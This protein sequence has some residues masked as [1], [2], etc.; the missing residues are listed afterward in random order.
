ME[1]AGFSVASTRA[2]LPYNT[3][4]IAT[5][6]QTKCHIDCFS[7]FIQLELTFHIVKKS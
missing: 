7:R 4:L 6:Y 2:K 1:V 3:A 5:E